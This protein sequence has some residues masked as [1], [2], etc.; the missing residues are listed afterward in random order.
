MNNAQKDEKH[1]KIPQKLAK[2]IL[3]EN[4]RMIEMRFFCFRLNSNIVW[5]LRSLNYPR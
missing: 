5:G 4:A 1:D 3:L 2:E